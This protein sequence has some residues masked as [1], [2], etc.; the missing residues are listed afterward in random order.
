MKSLLIVAAQFILIG[1]LA[2]PL[3]EPRFIFPA[4]VAVLPALGL[5]LWTLRHNRPGN[6]NIRPDLKEG[7]ILIM[8]GP[9]ALVRHPMYVV[10][11]WAGCGAL[12]LYASTLKLVLLVLLY[13]VLRFKSQIE[14]QNLLMEF[15]DYAEYMKKVGRF[16]PRR[17]PG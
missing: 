4:A 11:L 3:S 12:I 7:G 2:W 10:V 13:F 1:L 15:P 6:F 5:G 16:L 8:E 17:T 9:Y 14:E